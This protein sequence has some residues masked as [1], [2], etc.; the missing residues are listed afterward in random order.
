MMIIF[1]LLFLALSFSSLTAD[2]SYPIIRNF[3]KQE[4]H[5]DTQN[6][7]I[8]Q[9]DEGRM[10]FANKRGVLFYNGEGWNLY[11]FDYSVSARSVLYDHATDRLYTGG[12]NIF[13]FYEIDENTGLMTFKPLSMQNGKP[14]RNMGEIWNIIKMGNDWWFQGDNAFFKYDGK[15]VTTF[16]ANGKILKSANF[17]NDI[18]FVNDAG[19]L[20]KL[21]S[22]KIYPVSG[23]DAISGNTVRAITNHP[24]KRDAKLIITEFSGCY[25]LEKSGNGYNLTTFDTGIDNYLH[26]S[27]VFCA[28]VVE[29]TA[30]FGT[31]N[32]GAVIK[33]FKTEDT[34]F[35]NKSSGM[36]NNTVL[37]AAF[38]RQGN[39]WLGLDNGIDYVVYNSPVRRLLPETEDLGTGYASLLQGNTLYLGSNQGLFSMDYT[40]TNNLSAPAISRLLKGQIWGLTRVGNSILAATDIGVYAGS[41]NS[42]SKIDGIEGAWYVKPLPENKDLALVSAYSNYYLIENTPSG[43]RNIGRVT[44]FDGYHGKFIYDPN[45]SIWICDWRNGV[46]RMRLDADNRNFYD[47]YHFGKEQGLPTLNNNSIEFIDGSMLLSTE[48]GPM[49]TTPG[50]SEFRR[51]ERAY[52]IFRDNRPSH[53]YQSPQGDVIM[54]N[55]K[56]I[57]IASKDKKGKLLVDSTIFNAVKG[58]IV[59]GFEH[60]LFL[61]NKILLASERGFYELERGR[62]DRSKEVR[63]KL[64][65]DKIFINSDSLV[66]QPGNSERAKMCELPYKVSSVTFEAA[67]PEYR[68]ANSVTYSFK[69]EGYDKDW[70]PYSQSPRKEYTGLENGNYTLLVRAHNGYDNSVSEVEYNFKVATPWYKSLAARIVYVILLLIILSVTLRVIVNYARMKAAQAEAEKEREIELLKIEAEREKRERELLETRQIESQSEIENLQK[71]QEKLEKSH[72]SESLSVITKSTLQRN[73]ILMEMSHKLEELSGEIKPDSTQSVKLRKLIGEMQG[74][75]Q[76]A[77]NRNDDYS[78][79]AKNFDSVYGG[80][81]ARLTEQFPDLSK[82]EIKMACYIKMGLSTKEIAPLL[83]VAPKSVEMSRYRL[84]K[85]LGLDRSQNLSDFLQNF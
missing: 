28:D 51:A 78:D 1:F 41:G 10:I 17:G 9:D 15:S 47:V 36:Q 70:S 64:F 13:G 24:L 18:I 84:R 81:V 33:N 75:V 60:L 26:D 72:H 48:G 71:E 49:V 37:S 12:S 34:N 14:I 61:D 82:A 39:V 85:K 22:G 53:Y 44:G 66:S 29:N 32:A 19:K 16:P 73:E 77:L 2:A 42:M 57:A 30:V 67:M 63:N 74:T 11:R 43:W 65:I 23:A 25:T 56:H 68:L 45:G 76:K 3:T 52:E 79:I 54:I 50:G 6:W 69:L 7:D 80:Y 35:I 4:Y 5:A 38:D 58:E 59:P 46:Y 21:N 8:T 62:I 55:E 27:Q 20:F 83:S 40:A 31:V